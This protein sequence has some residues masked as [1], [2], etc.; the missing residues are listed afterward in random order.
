M[1]RDSDF[2]SGAHRLSA[3]ENSIQTIVKRGTCD[4]PELCVANAD[5]RAQFHFVDGIKWV[6]EAAAASYDVI[7][8]DSTDPIGPATGL[9][10]EPFYRDCLNALATGGIIVQQSES[11]LYHMQ[12][13][14]D[15]HT[16]MRSAGYHDVHT[17][18]FPQP[19]YPSGWW[20]ATMAR[21]DALLDSFRQ[22]DVRHKS[23]STQY[24]NHL[25]HAASLATPN[26]MYDMLPD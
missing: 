12:L 1:L 23:F 8:V 20:T 13:I 4:F 2:L 22:D 18:H 10:Q 5:P 17:L 7:I 26:F 21:K 6:K 9:F 11:P 24:Y 25:I 19:V 14:S 16:A 3:P 15:M